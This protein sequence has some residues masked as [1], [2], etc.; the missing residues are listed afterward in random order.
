MYIT[1][2]QIKEIVSLYFHGSNKPDYQKESRSSDMMTNSSYEEL[3]KWIHSITIELTEN[4][5][6]DLIFSIIK[7]AEEK[8]GNISQVLI[9]IFEISLACEEII[10]KKILTENIY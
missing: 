7:K 10:D 3:M 1:L 9:T 8:A 2:K 4:Q 5:L 6:K